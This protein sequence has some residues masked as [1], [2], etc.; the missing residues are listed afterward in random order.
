VALVDAV[1]NKKEQ[2]AKIDFT[3]ASKRGIIRTMTMTEV[4]WRKV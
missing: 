2:E 4:K 3:R 1:K